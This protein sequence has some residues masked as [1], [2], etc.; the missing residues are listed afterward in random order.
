MKHLQS[1]TSARGKCSIRRKLAARAVF[2][3]LESQAV[4][5]RCVNT[6][7][8]NVPLKSA[9]SDNHPEVK[10]IPMELLELLLL[11]VPTRP[12]AQSCYPQKQVY[13]TGYVCICTLCIV[14]YEHKTIFAYWE[15][16]STKWG[17]QNMAY[18]FCF[19]LLEGWG[20]TAGSTPEW[21]QQHLGC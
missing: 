8:L 6:A 20:L 21:G 7:V 2:S 11:L 15:S 1:L 3:V 18:V 17:S 9:R 4:L 16:W 14:L 13:G 10:R 12:V 5:L 19:P